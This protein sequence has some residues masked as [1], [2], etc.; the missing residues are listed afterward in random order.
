MAAYRPGGMRPIEAIALGQSARGITDLVILLGILALNFFAVAK[1]ITKAGYS[2]KW[3]WVPLTPVCLWFFTFILLTVDVRTLV[4]ANNATVSLPV[5]LGNFVLLEVIDFLSVVV[6]WVFF[7]IFAFST[8]PV[9]VARPETRSFNADPRTTFVPASRPRA[10][11]PG[12]TP[13]ISGSGAPTTMPAHARPVSLSAS[14][15]ASASAQTWPPP[16]VEKPRVIYCSWCGNQRASDAVAI[17]HCGSLDRPAVYC[18]NCGTPLGSGALTCTSC[19]T[20]ATSV[21]RS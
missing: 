16:S 7:L 6:T 14:A 10:G 20:P 8:W 2:P 9:S 11:S 12:L 17:H 5:S 18:M 3:I 15:S 13:D 1:I 21:S 19:G 4:L